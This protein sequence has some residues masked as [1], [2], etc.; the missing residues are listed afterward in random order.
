M[1]RNAMTRPDAHSSHDDT[2]SIE[3][4]GEL[5]EPDAPLERLVAYAASYDAYRL[6]ATDPSLLHALIAP[7]LNEWSQEGAIPGWAGPAALR[8]VLFYEYRADH[9]A[10]GYPEGEARMREVVAVLRRHQGEH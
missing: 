8:A 6:W 3:P 4:Y 9:F 7:I 10:G 1:D 2:R 5:P